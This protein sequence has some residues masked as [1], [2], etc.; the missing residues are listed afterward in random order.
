[1]NATAVKKVHGYFSSRKNTPVDVA[2]ELT[3]AYA[4][5]GNPDPREISKLFVSL[6]ELFVDLENLKPVD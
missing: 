6:V 1:M 4:G 3:R 5:S 2:Y